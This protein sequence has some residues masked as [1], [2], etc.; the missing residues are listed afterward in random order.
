MSNE[1]VNKTVGVIPARSGSKRILNKNL[2]ILRGLPLIDHTI[3]FA[4]SL[5]IDGCYITTDSLEIANRATGKVKAPFLRPES[6]SQDNSNDIEWLT[7]LIRYL[8][9]KEKYVPE[10]VIILRPTSP[11]RSI[12]HVVEAIKLAKC[13]KLSVRSACKIPT[14]M[15]LPWAIC[16]RGENFQNVQPDGFLL[17]SQDIQSYYYPTGIY[18]IVH[19]ETFLETGKIYGNEF[20]LFIHE[21]DILND[22]DTSED[23]KLIERNFDKLTALCSGS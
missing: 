21:A 23:L 1:I 19:V 7:H 6:I 12:K 20:K 3:R 13:S 10:L 9:E 16:Q 15:S 8:D 18:D 4:N 22:I 17:R 2:K 11:I 5:S 14:K